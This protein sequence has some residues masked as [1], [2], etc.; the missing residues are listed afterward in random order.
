MLSSR[1]PFAWFALV[2]CI[3][4]PVQQDEANANIELEFPFCNRKCPPWA[5]NTGFP[6]YIL[7]PSGGHESPEE[8]KLGEQ[9]RVCGGWGGDEQQSQLSRQRKRRETETWGSTE[10]PGLFQFGCNTCMISQ[11]TDWTAERKREM[12]FSMQS[13]LL[14]YDF[15]DW[16]SAVLVQKWTFISDGIWW[17]DLADCL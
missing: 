13:E 11:I 14:W 10:S 1:S 7:P 12:Q 8:T 2:K 15:W 3:L 16:F 6:G 4:E 17:S 9:S 5:H